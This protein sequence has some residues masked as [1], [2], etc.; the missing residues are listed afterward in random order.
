MFPP[1][2]RPPPK[3][4]Y[5]LEKIETFS[6]SGTHTHSHI[7]CSYENLKGV[8]FSWVCFICT[9]LPSWHIS[10]ACRR[11]DNSGGVRRAKQQNTFWKWNGK[12]TLKN[13]FHPDNV[14]VHLYGNQQLY[15]VPISK[16]VQVYDSKPCRYNL[17]AWLKQVFRLFTPHFEGNVYVYFW[18]FMKYPCSGKASWLVTFNIYFF[19]SFLCA[20]DLCDAVSFAQ[21]KLIKLCQLYV[22][23]TSDK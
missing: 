11:D 1:I 9:V 5:I 3:Y 16:C 4:K 8:F 20:C 10:W 15:V 21:F 7:P 22:V 6:V 23:V 18:V 14:Y 12:C 17:D 13:V 19:F 2:P